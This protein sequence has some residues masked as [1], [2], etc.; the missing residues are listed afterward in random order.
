MAEAADA[1]DAANADKADN[2]DKAVETAE[3][4]MRFLDKAIRLALVV[5]VAAMV[6]LV[7]TQVGLRYFGNISIDWADELS[8]LAFV[9]TIFL[10]MPLAVR[11]RSHIAI[12]LLLEHLPAAGRR[13]SARLLPLVSAAIAALVAWQAAV[14]I[15]EQWDELMASLDWSA[16][17]FIVPVALGSAL[18]AVFFIEQAARPA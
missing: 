18:C 4:L 5:I 17:W 3:A 7:A 13:V 11:T 9:W 10:G 1:A 15:V 12:D 8:R 14:L 16:Q 6:G 2:A